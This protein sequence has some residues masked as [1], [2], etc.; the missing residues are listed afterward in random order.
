[1]MLDVATDKTGKRFCILGTAPT[2]KLAPFDDPNAV[3][4]CLNDM[5]LLGIPRADTWTDIHPFRQFHFRDERQRK[6][7]AATVPAGTYVRPHGHIEW[8]AKQSI[9]VYI[10]QADPRVPRARVFPYAEIRAAFD[11]VFP[12]GRVE[13]SSTPQWMLMQA[14]LEGY[15]EIHIYGIHLATEWE[16]Q[17][18]RELFAFLIGYARGKGITVVIPKGSPLCRTTHEYA[19]APDPETPLRQM[20][21]DKLKLQRERAAI[22]AQV[23]GRRW[24]AG[25]LKDRLR[26]VDAQLA[27]MDATMGQRALA[28]RIAG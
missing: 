23:K 8:L 9:P 2:W 4:A 5:Y 17:K 19:Y 6:V 21:R 1:M 13:C 20:E 27:D 12:S 26:W 7:D 3:I 28:L 14:I 15:Q 11:P 18:Q 16:Y 10:Q 24:G 22:A 25:P